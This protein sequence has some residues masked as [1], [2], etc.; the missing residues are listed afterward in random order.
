MPKSILTEDFTSDPYWWDAAP[1]PE[2]AEAALPAQADVVV[3]GSGYTG[4]S[5]A[6]TLARGGRKVLVLEAG[7][8]GEGASTRNGGYA[9]KMSLFGFGDLAARFGL[10]RAIAVHKETKRGR[11]HVIGMIQREG[12]A[13]M[14][15]NPGR[16]IPARNP[17][18]Y[19]ALARELDLMRRHVE[20]EADMVPPEAQ[21][22]EIASN[23]YHGGKILHDSGD[24]HPGLF[25]Q[26]LVDRAEAAGVV[27]AARTPVLGVRR[28]G[29][30]FE[31]ST[32]RGMVRAR[33]VVL[34]TNG[35]T[36][37]ALPYF[38][39]R[40][41]PVN[42]YT[43]TTE[44]LGEERV[45]AIFPTGRNMI[46]TSWLFYAFRPTPDGTRINFSGRTGYAERAPAENARRLHRNMLRVFPQLEGVKISHCWKGGIG[47]TFD[48]MPHVG[49]RDGM[50]YALGMNGAGVLTGTFLGDKLARRILGEADTE[51]L[52]D[53]KGFPTVPLYDGRPWFLP[54]VIGWLTLKEGM[55]R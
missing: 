29:E 12:L 9:A 1:R 26:C 24:L 18:H 34:A 40:I 15:K 54:F 33:D 51:T 10:D 27:L 52:F 16:Y 36:D 21:R 25:H 7:R 2:P 38:R 32:N 37:T 4:L 14:Y 50:H 55:G 3:V 41:L 8:I 53:C 5:A 6:Q 35:Y 13:C 42:N 19:D 22:Q 46:D 20:I 47:M 43:I 45:R 39:R 23:F 30:R 31:V 49:M 11:D 48:F 17:R 28:E 44:P